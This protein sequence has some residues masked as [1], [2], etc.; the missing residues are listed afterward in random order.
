[1]VRRRRLAV[2]LL[3][4]GCLLLVAIYVL[5]TQGSRNT[6]GNHVVDGYRLGP[7]SACAYQLTPKC[8]L[9]IAAATRA[10]NAAHPTVQIVRASIARPACSEAGPSDSSA[11][12][13]SPTSPGG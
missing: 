11:R 5:Q 13:R 10:L 3:G 8:D 6:A 4:L 7:E 2:A 9:A 12:A 1:M